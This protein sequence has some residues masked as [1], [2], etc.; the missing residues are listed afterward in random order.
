MLTF[1]FASIDAAFYT[2]VRKIHEGK[3]PT[4]ESESRV[5]RIKRVPVPVCIEFCRPEHRVL[6]NVARDANPFFH[7]FESI[8][9]LA[10]R[11]D[12]KP[13]NY[14]NSAYGDIVSDDGETAN[15][16]YGYRWRQA[17]LCDQ[18]AM[19]IRELRSNPTSRRCVLQMWDTCSDLKK[20]SG[21]HYSKDVCCNTHI[22]FAI[23][24][25]R[26]VM[27]VCNRSN[28]MVWGMLGANVVH[29]SILQEHIAHSLYIPC[30]SYFQFTN[31]LHVYTEAGR[32]KPEEWL[33]EFPNMRYPAT[34]PVGSDAD[35]SSLE[36]NQFIDENWTGLAYKSRL[37]AMV[38][39]PMFDA[40]AFHK[41]REYT[42]AL[43]RLKD[44]HAEDWRRAGTEWIERRRRKYEE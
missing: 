27:T 8:W 7:L 3:I 44:V 10:G 28:D 14:F 37:L 21:R 1:S 42:K 25:G 23:R 9:M 11:N 6:F 18:I 31:D 33:A 5:G 17:H 16:A 13:L 20:I 35:L 41:Q 34:F 43:D 19:I 24:D 29:F 30:G 26:L 39:K 38:A 15:G 12:V 22:Y 4:V 40:F 36:C 2:L 32:W